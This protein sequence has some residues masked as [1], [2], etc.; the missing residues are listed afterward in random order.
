MKGYFMQTL[1]NAN[2]EMWRESRRPS[3]TIW[4]SGPNKKPDQTKI[5]ALVKSKL[6]ELSARQFIVLD[7]LLELTLRSGWTEAQLDL[8]QLQTGVGRRSNDLFSL[9][10]PRV[11]AALWDLEQK[12]LLRIT[13]WF[14]GVVTISFT[15]LSS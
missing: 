11:R 10:V 6:R 9:S 12:R 7:R 13:N 14:G 3:K 2:V 8:R 5:N 1:W 4:V 15:G